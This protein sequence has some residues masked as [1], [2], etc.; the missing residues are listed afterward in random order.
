MI[1]TRS[2]LSTLV[3]FLAMLPGCGGE[4][5]IFEVTGVAALLEICSGRST[6]VALC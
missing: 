5:G 1:R 4:L 2:A 6:A 3:G